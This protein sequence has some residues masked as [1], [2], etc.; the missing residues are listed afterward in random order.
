MWC[1]D[2]KVALLSGNLEKFE[3]LVAS[4]PKDLSADEVKEAMN[5]TLEAMELC[6]EKM[7]SLNLEFEKI[8][9]ARKFNKEMA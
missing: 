7:D 8:K 4:A 6:Q 9:K 5:L 1:D 3:A 2:L